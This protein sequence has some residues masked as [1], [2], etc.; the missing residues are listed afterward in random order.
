[1]AEAPEFCLNVNDGQDT[2]HRYPAFEECNLD[3]AD[4]RKRV[5]AR[6]AAALIAK[7]EAQACEHCLAPST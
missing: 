4:D 1:M 2:V 3:D 5:D 7:G 6:T